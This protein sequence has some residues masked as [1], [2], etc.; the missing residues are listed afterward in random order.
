MVGCKNP[1]GS[2]SAFPDH[3]K[4]I[5][6]EDRVAPNQAN[7]NTG[8]L[9]MDVGP[10]RTTHTHVRE[11]HTHSDSPPLRKDSALLLLGSKCL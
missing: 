8:A 11:P 5:P 10:E 6:G 4:C 1:A 2:V 7:R 3:Y 9:I